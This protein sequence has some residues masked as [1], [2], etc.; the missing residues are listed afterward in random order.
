MQVSFEPVQTPEEI[1]A[2]CTLAAEIWEEH[3]TPILEL[4]QVPYMVEKF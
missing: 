4:G 2:M 3:F 1:N